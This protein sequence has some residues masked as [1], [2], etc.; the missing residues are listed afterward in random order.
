MGE[1]G[2]EYRDELE[3]LAPESLE[4]FFVGWPAYPSPEEHLEIL[5]GSHAVWLALEGDR[6]VGFVNALSDG[7]FYAYLPLLE[8]LPSHQGR[9]IGRE[10]VRRMLATLEGMYAVD[11]LCDDELKGFYEPLGFRPCVGMAR[12]DYAA[13]GRL[14]AS[15]ERSRGPVE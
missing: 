6:C 1:L 8:V 10:L 13:Q 9:G 14:R 4:G 15:G 7:V 5:R 11:L 3:G 12:R 2:I